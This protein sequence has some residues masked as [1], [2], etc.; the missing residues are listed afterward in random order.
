[1]GRFGRCKA[2]NTT[3]L[4]CKLNAL[5]NGF[6]HTPNHKAQHIHVPHQFQLDITT[7]TAQPV[8]HPVTETGRQHISNIRAIQAT[9]KANLSKEDTK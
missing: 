9:A 8:S 5:G 2:L 4:R 7:Y 6:C 3:G 1:V